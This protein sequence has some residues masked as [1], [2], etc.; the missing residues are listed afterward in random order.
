MLQY[1]VIHV[2]SEYV[3]VMLG[4]EATRFTLRPKDQKLLKTTDPTRLKEK[5]SRWS[6]TSNNVVFIILIHTFVY[7]FNF[8]AQIINSTVVDIHV[9]SMRRYGTLKCNNVAGAVT[10]I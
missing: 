9:E 2:E 3:N 4:H 7:K 5:P 8:C 6:I 1:Y 10:K